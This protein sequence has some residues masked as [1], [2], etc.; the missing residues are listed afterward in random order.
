MEEVDQ[1]V[2]VQ[3]ARL[4]AAPP[5]AETTPFADALE[6]ALKTDIGD[7][8][9]APGGADEA[10][11]SSLGDLSA[12]QV[13]A[14]LLLALASAQTG[15]SREAVQS[16]S[17][18]LPQRPMGARVNA[19]AAVVQLLR[20]SGF[21]GDVSYHNILYPSAGALRRLMMWA[22]EMAVGKSSSDGKQSSK[23]ASKQSSKQAIKQAS[24]Q[25]SEQ[26]PE[27]NRAF[28]PRVFAGMIL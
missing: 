4:A 20:S 5:C 22:V 9:A 28:V 24:K 1:I 17:P 12:Q 26:E 10:E 18:H 21:Q 11:I 14:C 7:D 13:Y 15:G 25:A 8:S 2:L 3:L 16:I 19:A 27:K 6:G 23:Q